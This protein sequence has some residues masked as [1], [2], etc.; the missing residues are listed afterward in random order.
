MESGGI[1]ITLT[2]ILLRAILIDLAKIPALAIISSCFMLT[3]FS[4]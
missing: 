3:D 2:S 4:A 1:S